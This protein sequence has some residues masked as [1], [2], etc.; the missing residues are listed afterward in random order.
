MQMI[1]MSINSQLNLERKDIMLHPSMLRH[2]NPID[3]QL[4]MVLEWF[5]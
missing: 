1:V 4:Y 2:V 5:K 3:G